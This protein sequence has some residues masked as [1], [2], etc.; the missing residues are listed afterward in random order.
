MGE[1]LSHFI[2]LV[3]KFIILPKGLLLPI[4]NGSAVILVATATGLYFL[5]QV[6]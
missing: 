2:F 1:N 5:E 3:E 6:T 4:D